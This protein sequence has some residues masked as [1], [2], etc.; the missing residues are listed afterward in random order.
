VLLA[1]SL[2]PAMLEVTCCVPIAACWTLRAISWVAEPC[3]STAAA[4][5]AAISLISPMVEPMPWMALTASRV[6]V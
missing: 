3:S 1:S 4:M 2:T 5:D 6:A